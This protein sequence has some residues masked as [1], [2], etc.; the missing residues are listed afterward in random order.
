MKNFPRMQP[1]LTVA[2]L[3]LAL[4]AA[5]LFVLGPSRGQAS[6]TPTNGTAKP[7]LTVSVAQ[8]LLGR[9]P[10]S[11]AAN[12]NI[13]PWQ[14]ASVGAQANGLKLQEIRAAVGDT[15]RAG[16]VL[17]T[18]DD[19]SVR[20]DLALARANLLEARANAQ[21]AG[22]NA[23]RAR[24]LQDSGAWS[25]QQIAQYLTLE[26]TALA[27]V[28]AARAALDIQ[29][30]R[31]QHTQVLAPDRGVISARSATVGA[32][33]GAGTELFRM[34]RQGRLEW[35]AEVTASELGRLKPGTSALVT[36]PG[37]VQIRGKVRVLAP[38]VD[39][40]T[41]IA[42]VYVDLPATGLAA[43]PRAGMFA[44]GEF[45][46]GVTSALLVP[47]SALVLRD[48]FSYLFL[49]GADDRVA[50]IKVQ[51]GRSSGNQI[52]ITSALDAGARVV[53]SGAG[54]LNDGDRVRV[55]AGAATTTQ[56]APAPAA[57]AAGSSAAATKR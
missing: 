55:V 19:A 16:Q 11:L 17:A 57:P 56:P 53:S 48:G 29:Q 13:A 2:A 44:R 22:A 51:T 54:F 4:G 34:V 32:V 31:L 38:T 21:E 26:Q 1:S 41:R 9:L 23:A 28:E 52:E 42:L 20:A 30:L 37:G 35:R 7:A 46:L 27:R 8:P 25:T 15:V 39:S 45:E 50:R 33:V 3:T 14:E 12:G 49:V 10:V 36:L 6:D 5:A 43:P 24:S 18:F 47:Q 40:Q